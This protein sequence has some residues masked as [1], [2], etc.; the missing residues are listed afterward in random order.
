MKKHNKYSLTS[1]RKS[2]K[3]TTSFLIAGLL[4]SSAVAN[5][6]TLTLNLEG[7]VNAFQ[8]IGSTA[9]PDGIMIGD[10]VTYSFS[11]DADGGSTFVGA[12]VF[13]DELYRRFD[14]IPGINATLQ[15]G[16]NVYTFA[17]EDFNKNTVSGGASRILLSIFDDTRLLGASGPLL[18]PA[19]LDTYGMSVQILDNSA[20]YE[21][22]PGPM[23]PSAQDQINTGAIVAMQ[24]LFSSSEFEFTGN[25]GTLSRRW[26]VDIRF[27]SVALV[28]EP[29][30]TSLFLAGSS[31]LVLRRRRER[32]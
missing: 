24:G 14:Q 11:W 20:P 25:T 16:S 30:T 8:V 2:T 19:Q 1:A 27:D 32:K 28:P 18:H 23:I 12:G 26:L 31:L 6:A 4:G 9:I 21:L 13:A 3:S 10:A 7:R 17:S 5:A 29:A 15:I 22:L